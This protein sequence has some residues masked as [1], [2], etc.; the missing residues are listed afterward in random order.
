MLAPPPETGAQIIILINNEK[1][2]QKGFAKAALYLYG[3]Y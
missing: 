3:E 1:P 2:K